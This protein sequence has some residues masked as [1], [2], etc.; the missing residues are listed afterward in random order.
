MRNDFPLEH[1]FCKRYEDVY[2]SGDEELVIGRS[3]IYHL[4]RGTLLEK[5]SSQ[6]TC[7]SPA[8]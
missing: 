6:R 4:M 5:Y 8:A 3:V 7:I 2:L 1:S